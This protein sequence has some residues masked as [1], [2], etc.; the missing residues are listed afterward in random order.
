MDAVNGDTTLREA[1]RASHR[2]ILRRAFLGDTVDSISGAVGLTPT[3]V[4]F[5]MR[6]PLFQAA[7]AEL[8]READSKA[9][10]T[11]QRM[12]M[13]RDILSAAEEGI[14]IARSAM[15]DA[16]NPMVKAKIAFGFMDRSG[17]NPSAIARKDDPDNY[18]QIIE[19]L[20]AMERGD[21]APPSPKVEFS[22]RRVTFTGVNTP[23]TTSPGTPGTPPPA[24]RTPLEILLEQLGDSPKPGSE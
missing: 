24:T 3:S 16:R 21:S 11:A 5:I 8:Q 10:D 18:R 19:R 2:E 14:P 20:D 9:V 15:R 22:E 7:L 1:L 4:K 6:S 23:P 12:R 13:E 17:F